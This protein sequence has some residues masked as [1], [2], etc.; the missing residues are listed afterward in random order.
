MNDLPPAVTQQLFEEIDSI[1][2]EAIRRRFDP[3]VRREWHPFL[4]SL[5]CLRDLQDQRRK[6]GIRSPEQ[7]A[8]GTFKPEP[9]HW[10][11]FNHGGRNEAQFNIGMFPEYL[12]VGLG[13]EF[14][15][16]QG[17]RP[18]DVLFAYTTF[19]NLITGPKRRE[20]LSLV[21]Q[22]ELEIEF[23]PDASG[24]RANVASD[25]VLEWEPPASPP[26]RWI[27][28]GR[29]LRR[30][31]DRRILESPEHLGAVVESVLCGLH[32]LWRDTTREVR[33]LL[34]GL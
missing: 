16:K 34:R 33:R 22:S 32:P 2:E 7:E 14:T 25:R 29:L 11:S 12:R 26:I 15:E 3:W 1:D 13:F 5:P 20:F 18:S 30:D 4:N 19:R 6:F 31:E 8:F 9:Y 27:F 10:Y 21:E 24:K 28:Y 23:D 17:G